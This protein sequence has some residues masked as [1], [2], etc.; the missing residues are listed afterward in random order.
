M[1]AVQTDPSALAHASEEMR[2]NVRMVQEAITCTRGDFFESCTDEMKNNEEIVMDA[3]MHWGMNLAYASDEMKNN[4]AIVMTAL[5]NE[6]SRLDHASEE[7]KSSG[8]D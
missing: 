3:V 4:A 1:H 8:A 5:Q 7:M 2:S 6:G